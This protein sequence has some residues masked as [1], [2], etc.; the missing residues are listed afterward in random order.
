[1]ADD[2]DDSEDELAFVQRHLA[3]LATTLPE[4][5][6]RL[7]QA[8]KLR[9]VTAGVSLPSAAEGAA[10]IASFVAYLERFGR[11]DARPAA[12]HS[13]EEIVRGVVTLVRPELERRAVV[14]ERY[15]E[16]PPV[17]GAERPLSQLF[18]NLVINAAQAIAEGH[19]ADNRIEVRLGSDGRGWAVVDI[20][21]SGSGIADDV[22]PHIFEPHFSTKR[23]GGKGLGLSLTRQIV[24]ELGGEIRFESAVG[25][26]TRFTVALPPATGSRS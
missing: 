18:L 19:A 22:K 23:G 25:R 12:P 6:E 17:F 10:R 8:A 11:P 24:G 9:G 15:D 20:E 7:R 26:G 3:E 21:D 2:R 5:T 14:V 4:L 1:M 16:A 13:L